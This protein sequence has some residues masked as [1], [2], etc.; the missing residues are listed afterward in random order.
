[1]RKTTLLLLVA[2]SVFGFATATTPNKIVIPDIEG[3]KTL[4]GDFHIHTVFSD[5][6]VWPTTRVQEALWEGL[7]VIAITDHVDSRLQKQVKAGLFDAEKCDRDRSFK[8][9]KKAAG[10]DLIVIHGGEISRGMPPGHW[11][12][13][14]VSDC[15]KI[16]AAAEQFDDDHFKAMQAGLKEAHAQGGFTM[17]NHP[18]WETQ[19][20]NET[21]WWKEHEKLYKAGYMQGIEVYN[22]FCGYSPEAHKWALERGLTMFADSDCHTPFFHMIDYMNGQHRPVTLVFAKERSEEGVRDALEHGRTA[23]FAE[24]MVYGREDM[25][26]LLFEACVKVENVKFT[27]GQVSFTLVNKSCIPIRLRKAAGSEKYR[28]VRNYELR[29]FETIGVKVRPV[30]VDNRSQKFDTDKVEVNFVA[31]TFQIGPDTPLPVTF[32]FNK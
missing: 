13:L 5:A 25:L 24:Q 29:P 23:A 8:I 17:W 4:K 20:P 14:F 11:N 27:D 9:A 21:K 30:L 26:R 19:A 32:R 16:C 2:L 3:Y 22:K 6:T 1:M 7:D 15:N 28:Y 10:K 18:N 31:E 12:C